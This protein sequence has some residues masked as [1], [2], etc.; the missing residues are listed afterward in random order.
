M[1]NCPY[2]RKPV[3]NTNRYKRLVN[4]MI[5]TK[6]NPIKRKI[7]GNTEAIKIRFKEL[8]T[9]I[10]NI[11]KKYFQDKNQKDPYNLK[12]IFLLFIKFME[13]KNKF[14][15]LQVEMLITYCYIIETVTECWQAYSSLK[16]TVLEAEFRENIEMILKVLMISQHSK[17]NKVEIKISE[18][19]QK[20]V[21]NEIKRLNSIV[22]LATLL[23]VD[24]DV[25]ADANIKSCV[26]DA[27]ATVLTFSIFDEGKAIESLNTLKTAIKSSE[28]IITKLARAMVIK[29]MPDMKA[30]HWFKCPN[31]HFYCIG[32]CGGANQVGK[33]PD[34]GAAVGGTRHT[35]L[36]GNT[37]TGELDGSRYAAY[38]EEANN[39]ANFLL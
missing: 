39:M 37:H 34:C 36:P 22:Q 2:C 6:I 35:L 13:K 38:S 19:Q 1:K 24:S 21:D 8:E 33:C 30:G 25:L 20:N 11:Y 7:Y 14:F 15:L 17:K 23:R 5:K 26:N 18:Q 29:A 10:S 28:V 9:K 31:G 32:E 4:D 3:I 27:K 16:T 12:V